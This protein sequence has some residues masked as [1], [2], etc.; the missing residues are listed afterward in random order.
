VPGRTLDQVADEPAQVVALR[1]GENL[2]QAL[3]DAQL[4]GGRGDAGT[5]RFA[6]L[7]GGG[8]LR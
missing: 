4:P 1:A 2:A 5:G 7:A 6:G 8:D 3:V